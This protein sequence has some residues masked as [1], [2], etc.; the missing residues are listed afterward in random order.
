MQQKRWI[1]VSAVLLVGV[2]LALAW[3]HG[4]GWWWPRVRLADG[5]ELRL[6]AR[7]LR[8]ATEDRAASEFFTALVFRLRGMTLPP[9]T[10]PVPGPPQIR[11]RMV[12]T[13]V[14]SGTD[15]WFDYLSE[16]GSRSV[17]AGA[18][19]VVSNA[20]VGYITN[21]HL[22]TFPRRGRVVRLHLHEMNR[23]R[24]AGRLFSFQVPNPAPGPH[25][26]WQSEPLPQRK[27]Q[28][29]LAVALTGFGVRR[30]S[31]LPGRS[32]R[33]EMTAHLTVRENGGPSAAWTA[34]RRD[35][36]DAT[37]NWYLSSSDPSPAT[38]T[39]TLRGLLD[40]EPIP[41]EVLELRVRF[42]RVR[43]DRGPPATQPVAGSRAAGPIREF[44]FRIPPPPAEP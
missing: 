30:S 22:R 35:L 1:T 19:A 23:W 38:S 6:E 27:R 20:K 25:P 21:R 28:G 31:G 40:G 11:L 26:V 41:G 4:T 7:A 9:R 16:A 39:L 13:R 12:R 5:S 3:A 34:Y 14:G 37:G 42:M 17:L 15:H 29:A 33:I 2:A 44:R 8:T 10:R 43:G 24:D 36:V 32:R 18:H